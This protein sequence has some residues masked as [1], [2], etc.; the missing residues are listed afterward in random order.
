VLGPGIVALQPNV[1]VGG[2]VIEGGVTS[3]IL[4]IV[5]VQ[6]AELPQASVAL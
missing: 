4:V 3:I 2:Q 6:V 1:S 5:C